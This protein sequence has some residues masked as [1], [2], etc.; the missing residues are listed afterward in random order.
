MSRPPPASPLCPYTTLFRSVLKPNEAMFAEAIAIGGR[1]GMLVT[2]EPSIASMGAEFAGDAAKAD[3]TV[4]LE[5]VFVP[6]AMAAL[7]AR[8]EEHTSELQSPMY[9]AC[10]LL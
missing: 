6:H 4:T 3:S 9:L 5:S 1:I 10:R 7:L 8:S 2:F